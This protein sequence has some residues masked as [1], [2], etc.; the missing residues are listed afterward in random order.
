V[1]CAALRP[2]LAGGW[3]APKAPLLA[4]PLNMTAAYSMWQNM[5]A[6]LTWARQWAHDKP[7]LAQLHR[8]LLLL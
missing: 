4:V 3:K 5:D 1:P 6:A 8:S 2:A 7:T